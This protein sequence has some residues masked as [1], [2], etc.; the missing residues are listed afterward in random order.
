MSSINS[1]LG[2]RE[3]ALSAQQKVLTVPNGNQDPL[4]SQMQ[5]DFSDDEIKKLA[6][7]KKVKQ[8]QEEKVSSNAKERIKLLSDLGKITKTVVFDDVSFS[9]K[10]LKSGQVKYL[11]KLKNEL[12]NSNKNPED[13]LL[14]LRNHSIAC[15]LYEI[16]SQPVDVVLGINSFEDLLQ[17]IDELDESL[18]A[19]LYDTYVDILN[20][21]KKAALKDEEDVKEVTEDIKK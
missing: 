7:L 21:A 11:T 18:T 5:S 13:I 1:P 17:W 6:Q 4:L 12:L 2:R 10:S 20:Q 14:E 15:S 3:T 8:T 16:D 9:L 19:F